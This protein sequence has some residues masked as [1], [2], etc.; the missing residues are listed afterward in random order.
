[1]SPYG[2]GI[3]PSIV[4]KSI[5][6]TTLRQWYTWTYSLQMAQLADHPATGGLLHHL[7]TLT[8]VT[9]PFQITSRQAVIFFYRHQLS[10]TASIFGSGASYA[11]RTFLS[12]PKGHQRQAETLFSDCKG[13]K[14][15]RQITLFIWFLFF[16]NT[17]ICLSYY[18]FRKII[19]Y[20]QLYNL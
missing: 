13:T 1:M 17:P 5:G 6:R 8:W 3:L 20:I 16:E 9:S 7:L 15:F 11:A 4:D 18:I 2:S 12:W 14:I 19:A 10:P